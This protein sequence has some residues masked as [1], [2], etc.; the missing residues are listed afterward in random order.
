MLQS[1]ITIPCTVEQLAQLLDERLEIALTKKSAAEK[2]AS[3][4]P[5]YVTRN[6]LA[7]LARVSLVT[8]H[9]W[10]K[11]TEDRKAIIKPIRIN[12]RVRY[13]REDVLALLDNSPKY[14]RQ[15]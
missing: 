9:E 14:R 8:L 11:D 7:R 15:S 3:Q 4:L 5:D 1:Y 12:G 10:S 13:K 2:P 6:E